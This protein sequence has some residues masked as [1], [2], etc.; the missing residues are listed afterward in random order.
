LANV[1]LLRRFLAH[2][3]LL[4]KRRADI[5]LLGKRVQ[6][7]I[8][9]ETA[10]KFSSSRQTLDRY[11]ASGKG[12]AGIKLQEIRSAD[13]TFGQWIGRSEA[14]GKHRRDIKLL[15]ASGQI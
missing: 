1:K 13:L 15:G 3:V 2:I 10:A 14:A 8:Y 7:A 4:Q 11:Q 9:L 6:R 12:W 5:K